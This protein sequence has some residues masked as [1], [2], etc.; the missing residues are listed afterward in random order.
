MKYEYKTIITTPESFNRIIASEYQNGWEHIKTKV[1][2]KQGDWGE[3]QEPDY[4]C[5]FRKVVAMNFK[6]K[7]RAIIDIIR[8]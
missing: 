4:H 6:E 1:K 2:N 7:L 5:N 3:D 8:L